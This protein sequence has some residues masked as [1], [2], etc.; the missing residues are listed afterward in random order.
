MAAK[1]PTPLHS[2]SHA[3]HTLAQNIVL[4]IA[5]VCNQPPTEIALTT[6][7]SEF[8]LH[9]MTV[10]RLHSK[11][12]HKF[13]FRAPR[14]ALFGDGVTPVWIA[15]M[16]LGDRDEDAHAAA[17]MNDLQ[18]NDTYRPKSVQCQ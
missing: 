13:G 14:T 16:I 4:E 2:H 1:M 8:G 17:A 7:L 10:T 5:T 18:I 9:S 6:P 12:K 15:G 11:L 3:L